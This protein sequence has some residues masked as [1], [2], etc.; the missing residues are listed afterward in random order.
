MKLKNLESV[1]VGKEDD[2]DCDGNGDVRLPDQ[3]RH[4]HRTRR[5]AAE[6]RS[7]Q[8]CV[9]A[10][11][12]APPAVLPSAGEA[13]SWPTKTISSGGGFPWPSPSMLL[14]RPDAASVRSRAGGP[15]QSGI[16]LG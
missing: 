14:G 12:I 7:Y 2:C 1:I 16:V 5:N 15:F 10:E 9:H 11:P 13:P 6:G 4:E 8:D 3:S